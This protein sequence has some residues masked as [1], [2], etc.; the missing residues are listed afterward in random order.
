MKLSTKII[1]GLAIGLFAVPMLVASYLVSINRVDAKKYNAEVEQEVSKPDAKDVYFRSFPLA[2]F[3][4]LYIIG[5]NANGIGL[6]WVKSDKFMVKVNKS[7]AEYVKTSVDQSGNLTL[8]FLPGG[9]EFYKSI[10]IF[11]PDLKVLN[12]KNAGINELSAKLNELTVVG[13]SVDVFSLA[14]KS[15]ITTLNLNLTNS[16]I[17][18]LGGT[19]SKGNSLINRLFVNTTNSVLGLPRT[20]YQSADIIA[21]NSEVYFNRK[22]PN[23]KVDFLNIKTEGSS[24]VRLDSLQWGA[25]NGSLSN[26]T[27]IDLPVHALRSLI[28]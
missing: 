12:L 2:V 23:A 11:S 18:D 25:L 19:D 20:N 28:K 10:Y 8:D 24:S 1:M 6:H 13:D 14:E 15:T 5:K 21:N 3:D 17:D 27:K 9:D 22:G 16:T 7:Q 26:D 4:K